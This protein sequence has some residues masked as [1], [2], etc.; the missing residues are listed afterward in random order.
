MRRSRFTEEHIIG[1]LKE[2]DALAVHTHSTELAAQPA[3]AH[4]CKF[5][6]HRKILL[7]VKQILPGFST[8]AQRPWQPLLD[9]SKNHRAPEPVFGYDFH[10]L[11]FSPCCRLAKHPE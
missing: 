1:I 8:E 4:P 3:R 11:V 2:R 6:H 10:R 9:G 7:V 5:T